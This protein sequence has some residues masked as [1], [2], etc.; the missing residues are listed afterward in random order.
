MPNEHFDTKD[1]NRTWQYGLLCP[2]DLCTVQQTCHHIAENSLLHF[3][4]THWSFC[5]DRE[6]FFSFVRDACSNTFKV[7]IDKALGH[8]TKSGKV[9]DEDIRDLFYGDYSNPDGDRVYAEISDLKS[10]MSV[11]EQ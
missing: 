1:L 3:L 8:L 11:M 2:A 5:R 4:F 6:K 10:L 7:N 9:T